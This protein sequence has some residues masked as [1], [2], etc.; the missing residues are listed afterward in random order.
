MPP[1][2]PIMMQIKVFPGRFESLPAIGDFV[3]ESAQAAGLDDSAVYA[4]QLAVD[5]AATNVIEHAYRGMEPGDL[6]CGCEILP[7]GIKIILSDH[8]RPFD[9]D[10]VPEPETNAPLEDV[11]PRGLGLFFM[12]KMMDE[13]RFEF[14][15]SNG[16]RLIMIKRK[17]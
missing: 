17:H 13:M 11:K 2:Q 6:E 14:S 8:G 3:I 10:Q 7:N 15:E 5:E 12:R 4:V 9:P 16:N 1:R